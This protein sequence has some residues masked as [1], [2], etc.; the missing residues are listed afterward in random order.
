MEIIRLRTL[1]RKSTIG[2][3]KYKECNVDTVLHAARGHLI[4][5][6]YNVQW[7]NFNDDVLRALGITGKCCRRSFNGN[8]SVKA[9]DV[10]LLFY[11]SLSLFE[12]LLFSCHKLGKCDFC[13]LIHISLPH[14]YHVGEIIVGETAGV[15]LVKHL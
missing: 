5:L 7:I 10:K 13:I 12:H 2:W 9:L 4:W 3:G 15:F 1:T 6:Y 8:C 11:G 14:F